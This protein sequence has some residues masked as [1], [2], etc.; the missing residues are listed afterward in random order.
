MVLANSDGISPVQPFSGYSPR[1]S[2]CPYGTL[3]LYGG[4]SQTLQVRFQSI[5]A[6]LLPRNS[7][8]CYGLGSSPF[9]RHYLRNHYYFLFLRVLR[10]F[11]SPGWPPC[12][13]YI[14]NI[15]GCPIRI[16]ADHIV[17]ANPRSFSQLITSFFASGSQGIPHTPLITSDERSFA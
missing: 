5:T 4:P 8:N 12:G 9:A 16:S 13:C 6:V 3:T 14:F 15:A 10:C 17:C 1:S 11:S 2:S 7:L